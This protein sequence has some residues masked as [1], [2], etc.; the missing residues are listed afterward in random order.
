MDS[1]ILDNERY[2]KEVQV[3]LELVER[4]IH[5]AIE[6]DQLI[7]LEAEVLQ[8]DLKEMG[9]PKIN[10]TL[11]SIASRTEEHASILRE[12]KRKL[13]EA[14]LDERKNDDEKTITS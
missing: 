4:R 9:S 13:R 11:Q 6:L 8:D 10:E 3:L 1:V 14:L 5:R 2:R 12:I 7:L